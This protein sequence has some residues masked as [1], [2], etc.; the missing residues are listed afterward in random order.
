MQQHILENLSK[1]ELLREMKPAFLEALAE[2][3]VERTLVSDETL[4]MQHQEATGFYL[5]CT[6][7]VKVYRIGGDGREQVIHQ[8]GPGEI[9]GEVPVFQ[10]TAYPACATAVKKSRL[11][12]FARNRFVELGR[13]Q[14]EIFLNML[15]ILSRRL[16][17]F[18]ELIDDLSL[19][20]VTAR[21]AKYLARGC[22]SGSSCVVEL[23]LSKSALASRIGTIP[24]TLSRTFK[25]LQDSGAIKVSASKIHILDCEL[26]ASI[27]SGEKL[28]DL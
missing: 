8:F 5:I 23:E 18:V 4:F 2:I 22:D 27:A 16:R 15:A 26:L 25:K 24:A 13:R 28:G 19:K 9:V 6:G 1:S 10:G 21:L 11:I 14:P 3:A 20:D 12:Y 7:S 17:Q